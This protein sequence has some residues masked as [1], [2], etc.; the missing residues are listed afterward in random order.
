MIDHIVLGVAD[1]ASGMVF[2]ADTLGA[3]V[4]VG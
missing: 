4:P 1:L 3:V 2:V